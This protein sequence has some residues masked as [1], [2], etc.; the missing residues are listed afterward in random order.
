[1][2]CFKTKQAHLQ[3]FQILRK[4]C[5]RHAAHLSII[6]NYDDPFIGRWFINKLLI[7][8][9]SKH[10]CITSGDNSCSA[11]FFPLHEYFTF[12]IKKLKKKNNQE[13]MAIA[14]AARRM[15]PLVVRARLPW[16]RCA[17][18]QTSSKKSSTSS[19]SSSKKSSSKESSSKG[20]SSKKSS[21]GESSSKSDRLHSTDIGLCA[22]N[23][24]ACNGC[25]R[26]CRRRLVSS[27][28][29]SRQL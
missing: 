5:I 28:K 6:I 1:M 9:S 25:T 22:N 3:S 8:Q 13:I 7:N 20:S 26:T 12:K 24:P 11:V 4:T 14:M 18:S 17:A 21:G 19:A 10:L 29:Y 15:A 27:H 16:C 23:Y 2:N